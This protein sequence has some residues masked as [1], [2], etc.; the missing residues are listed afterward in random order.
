MVPLENLRDALNAS[1]ANL[2]LLRLF[3]TACLEADN[4]AAARSACERFLVTESDNIEARILLAKILWASG[5]FSEAVVRLEVLLAASPD[6]ADAWLLLSEILRDE[7]NAAEADAA[8]LHASELDTGITLN[9]QPTPANGPQGGLIA[10]PPAGK[11]PVPHSAKEPSVKMSL[12]DFQDVGGMDAVKEEIRMKILHPIQRPDLFAAYGKKAGGGVLLYGPPGCGK[13]LLSRATA[14]EIGAAFHSVGIHEILDLWLGNSEKNLHALFERARRD[15]PSV[16]FF[17][18]VDAL[19]AD[20]SDL[21][22]TEGKTLINQ[23]LAELD[24]TT[25]RNEGVLV[26]GATNA[27][28]HLD[29]AFRRPGRFDRIMFVPPPDLA[30]RTAIIDILARNR[31]VDQLDSAKIAARTNGFSGADLAG[32]FDRAAEQALALALKNGQIQSITTE[33][34]LHAMKAVKPS[35]GAWFESARNYA[36]YANQS[37]FYDE[38]L[39]FLKTAQ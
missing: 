19:A 8:F 37:G 27:P 16:L 22:R 13:T 23:F 33:M 28:W 20:R 26:L 36:L 30:G 35:T 12:P 18:E 21:K 7:G 29:P 25:E 6:R 34:L 1:P 5:C 15:R 2:P 32:I 17:D 31:P 4:P 24:A 11:N 10:L 3:I 39:A 9:S 14:G 38:V